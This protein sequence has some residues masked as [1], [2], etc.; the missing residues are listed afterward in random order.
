MESVNERRSH[1]FVKQARFAKKAPALSFELRP[2]VHAVLARSEEQGENFVRYAAGMAQ[3]KRGKLLLGSVEPCKTPE[4]RARI[5]SLLRHEPPLTLGMG[6]D[7]FTVRDYLAY[8]LT[9]R[10]HAT[11]QTGSATPEQRIPEPQR[12]PELQDVPYVSALLDRPASS[13]DNQER[14]HVALGLALSIAEPL[15]LVLHDPLS[16]LQSEVTSSLLEKLGKYAEEGTIVACVVPTERSAR[17]LSERI[18]RLEPT[19]NG[20]GEILFLIRS[21][22]PRDVASTLSRSRN[23]LSTQI[24]PSGDL[25]VSAT[26]EESA[27]ADITEALALTQVEVFEVRRVAAPEMRK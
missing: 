2:Q 22:R 11:T 16:D 27:A 18:H 8:V 1:L 10:R 23:I 15:L 6:S 3:P 21:E 17:Q 9:L 26:S 20:E 4:L 24:R 25:I 12:A 7:P 14:R 19:L 13:L 5:G